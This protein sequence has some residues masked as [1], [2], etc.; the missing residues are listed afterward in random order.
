MRSKSYLPGK[1][2]SED[3]DLLLEFVLKKVHGR[4]P[5]GVRDH[6]RIENLSKLYQTPLD[7]I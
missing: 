2:T 7:P 5:K 4:A 6:K 3:F 1:K